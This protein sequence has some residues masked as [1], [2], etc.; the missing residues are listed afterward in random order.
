MT[1]LEVGEVGGPHVRSTDRVVLVHLVE[2]H[3]MEVLL[4]PR[5]ILLNLR[6][7]VRAVLL[8]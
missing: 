3:A 8:T 1:C 4:G 6:V 7:G 2:V 5:V